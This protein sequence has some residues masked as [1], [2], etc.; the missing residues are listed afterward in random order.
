[1]TDNFELN[2]VTAG[3]QFD[4]HFLGS[5]V[6]N[7][8]RTH[9]E[10]ISDLSDWPAGGDFSGLPCELQ[11]GNAGQRRYFRHVVVVNEK[12]PLMKGFL[13]ELPLERRFIGIDQGVHTCRWPEGVVY[14]RFLANPMPLVRE[15]I[16]RQ[17]DPFSRS[18]GA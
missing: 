13:E 12:V 7:C 3:L 2:R 14:C 5:G 10:N 16:G 6:L 15:G 1:M 9:P 18:I 8:N 4:E 11:V 17:R